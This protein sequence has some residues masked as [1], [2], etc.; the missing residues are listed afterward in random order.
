MNMPSTVTALAPVRIGQGD[1]LLPEPSSRVRAPCARRALRSRT[2]DEHR[3]TEAAFAPY[4][5]SDPLHYRCFLQAQ[6]LALPGIEAAVAQSGCAWS[7][8]RPRFGALRADLAAL[9]IDPPP[10][11]IASDIT[12]AASAWGTQYVLEGSR[13]GGILLAAEV[14]EGMPHAFLTPPAAHGM[15][16][17]SFQE[18][19]E[20]A[21]AAAPER[22]SWLDA[23]TDAAIETF[24]VF[25][26]GASVMTECL[27]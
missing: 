22:D 4:R 3:A 10:S 27:P 15:R 7:G 17:R 20:V 8:W 24:R 26:R 12:D 18:E 21:Y 9:V 1:A 2:A 6:A 13:L 14:P 23:A 25:R 16:W 19:M 5:V 11:I